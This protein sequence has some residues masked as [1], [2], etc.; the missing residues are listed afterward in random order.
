[1]NWTED[2]KATLTRLYN[3][4]KSDKQIQQHF[5]II[6]QYAIPKQRSLMGLVSCSRKG[7]K[8][9]QPTVTYRPKIEQPQVVL[10]YQKDNQQHFV[11][12]SKDSAANVAKS[13]MIQNNLKEV[14]VLKPVSKM[15]YQAVKEVWL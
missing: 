2:N 1:M 10:S 5:G 12:V 6:E 3:E 7:S 15:I 4:G 8:K 14:M 11:S 13:L 9:E